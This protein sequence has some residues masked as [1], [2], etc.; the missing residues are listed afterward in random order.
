MLKRKIKQ[1]F[2]LASIKAALEFLFLLS[3]SLIGRFSQVYVHVKGGFWNSFKNHS[4]EKFFWIS[5]W[6]QRSNLNTFL[7][8]EEA[9]KLETISDHIASTDEIFKTWKKYV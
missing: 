6:F 4:Y 3:F 9:K 8:K 7:P 5:K 2:M 1:K